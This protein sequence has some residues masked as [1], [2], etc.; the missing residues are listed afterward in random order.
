M[1]GFAD[2][3]VFVAIGIVYY[4]FLR[5]IGGIRHP[6][7]DSHEKREENDI[8]P[9]LLDRDPV[10]GKSIGPPPD[11]FTMER[12]KAEILVR[13]A[14]EQGLPISDSASNIAKKFITYD[15]FT[16]ILENPQ[17]S[18]LNLMPAISSPI[19]QPIALQQPA[20]SPI[21]Q[22]VTSSSPIDLAGQDRIMREAIGGVRSA[23]FSEEGV[24]TVNNYLR[25]MGSPEILGT[26]LIEAVN[27][28]PNKE[29]GEFATSRFRRG[30]D[31]RTALLENFAVKAG[32]P[33]LLRG[34]LSQMS[35]QQANTVKGYIYDTK[36][37]KQIP[38]NQLD[39]FFPSTERDRLM[40]EVDDVRIEPFD[41]SQVSAEEW[42][43]FS[44]RVDEMQQEAYG[45]RAKDYAMPAS[46]MKEP[47]SRTLLAIP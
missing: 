35:S 6:E 30:N 44:V 31:T 10:C 23:V 8:P 43:T 27:K 5:A 9:E 22:Q 15:Q 16:Q 1:S 34:L 14:E 42:D 28:E 12:N 3:W 29:F 33:E 32:S 47:S 46:M 37:G 17:S 38:F 11:A 20:D 24:H 41:A 39:L 45:N 4:Y 19:Q 40:A 36:G 13:A 21:I 18:N 2:I 25:R 7:E 26:L